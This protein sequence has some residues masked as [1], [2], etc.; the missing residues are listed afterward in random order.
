MGSVIIILFLWQR[1]QL[2]WSEIYYIRHTNNML[3]KWQKVRS[4]SV[5]PLS[6]LTLRYFALIF[7]KHHLKVNKGK[8][9]CKLADSFNQARVTRNT[10]IILCGKVVAIPSAVNLFG[11]RNY[12]LLVCVNE[13]IR[14]VIF[15]ISNAKQSQSRIEP[16]LR[17]PNL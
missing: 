7:K 10:P 16:D 1:I 4:F 11:A 9:N 15:T 14:Y 8:N 2:C 5:V 17:Y 6:C 3:I 13:H 12:K